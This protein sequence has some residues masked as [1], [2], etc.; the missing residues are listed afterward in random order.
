MSEP[1]SEK[2][3]IS[4]LKVRQAEIAGDVKAVREKIYNGMSAK[5]DKTH[6]VMTRLE[7]IIAHHATVVSNIEN[8]G[9]W[10]SRITLTAVIGVIFWAVSKGFK[11]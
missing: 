9:W 11:V 4:E 2:E 10:L 5:I 8:M 1:C 7:P 3:T 6:D